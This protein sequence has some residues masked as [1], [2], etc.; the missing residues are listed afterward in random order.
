VNVEYLLPYEQEP[1]PEKIF[2][3]GCDDTEVDEEGDVCQFCRE[4]SVDD[5]VSTEDYDAMCAAIARRDG[6]K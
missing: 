2:C 6:K 1:E 5:W 4:S 3:A